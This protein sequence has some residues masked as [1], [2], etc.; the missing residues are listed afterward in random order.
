MAKTF[1][2]MAELDP[3][4]LLIVDSLNLGFRWK[5]SGDHKF[6]DAY[7]NTVES[8]RK[9]YLAGKVIIT[10][11][12]GS[13]SYRKLIYPEYKGNRE[14]QRANQT[15]EEAEKFRIF[16]DEFTQVLEA[17]RE[18]SNYPVLRYNKVEA[19]DIAAYI[20]KNKRKYNIKK[21]VLIS[22]DRDWDL[23]VSDTTMRFSY[24]TRKEVRLDNWAEHYEYTPE[25]HISIKCLMGDSGD[26]V[27]GVDKIGPVTAKK[28]LA[29]Y[30]TTY[31]IIANMPLPGKYQYIKNLNAFGPEALMLN[32]QLMDLLEFCEDAIGI[33]NC[34]D[35]H[36]KL[37]EYLGAAL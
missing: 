12:G 33:D 3:Q 8:L 15:P 32:Y 9:S 7:I 1:K 29:Q 20:V 34:Q 21:I 16:F 37:E 35:L 31:D 27:P 14:E 26:N 28:L 24:V 25:Q 2:S 23:L 17:F 6:V 22:S 13:S 4:T 19:D 30:E 36:L 10:A 5:H 11:D 18:F